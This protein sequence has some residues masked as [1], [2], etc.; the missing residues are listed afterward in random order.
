[1]PTKYLQAFLQRMTASRQGVRSQ[2]LPSTGEAPPEASPEEQKAAKRNV[3]K[4]V[5]SGGQCVKTHA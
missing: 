4:D 3:Q 5:R 1:M 2:G